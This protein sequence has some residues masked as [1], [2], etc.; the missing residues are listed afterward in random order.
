ME[1]R[2]D[3]RPEQ[4][5]RAHAEPYPCAVRSPCPPSGSLGP[6]TFGQVR[7]AAEPC[8]CL[9]GP[10]ASLERVAARPRTLCW[11]SCKTTL[12]YVC[13]EMTAISTLLFVAIDMV[14]KVHGGGFLE[15]IRAFVV[16]AVSFA[17]RMVIYTLLAC[18]ILGSLG[19]ALG[20]VI[21]EVPG[22]IHGWRAWGASG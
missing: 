18:V 21:E 12:L 9:S 17:V 22:D 15:L 11:S 8:G 3:W 7:E 14:G 20:P 10:P 4:G 16:S 6:D 2:L 1:R 13:V 19:D 5:P